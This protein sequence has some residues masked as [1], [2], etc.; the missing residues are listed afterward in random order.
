[1]IASNCFVELLKVEA[2]GVA[3]RNA[4]LHLCAPEGLATREVELAQGRHVQREI[5]LSEALS[6]FNSS[7]NPLK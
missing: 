6:V 7:F 3:V 5:D 1:M 2:G 4:E